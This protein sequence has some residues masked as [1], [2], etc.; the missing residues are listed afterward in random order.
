MSTYTAKQNDTFE[1][2][3]RRMYGTTTETGRLRSANPSL[4]DP[5]SAGDS[6]FVPAAKRIN[7]V[8]GSDD[9]VTLLINGVEYKYFTSIEF[10]QRFDSFDSILVTAPFEPENLS[11]R[12]SF[13]PFSYADI[14]VYIGQSLVFSGTQM[15]L[16]PQVTPESR[17]IIL[18][19]YSRCAVTNDS[20]LPV[21]SYPI[22]LR[23]MKLDRI[24]TE[25]CRP[26]PFSVSKDTDVGAVFDSASIGQPEKIYTFLTKLAKQRDLIITNDAQG[27]L[28]ITK[29]INSPS[30]AQ[31]S[32]G[33][34]PVVSVTPMHDNQNYFSDYTAIIPI[35]LDGLPVATY[36]AKN[37]RLQN[38][39][40][41]DNFE[42]N[43]S[44]NGEEKQVAESRRARGLA[45]SIAYNVE[46]ATVRDP[47][48]ALYRAGTFVNLQAIN[49]MIYRDTK[50][51]IRSVSMLLDGNRKTC[52][53]D[54]VLP[55]AYNGEDVEV[56]PWE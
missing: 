54:L 55:E 32:D 27:D 38:V 50:F 41:V 51:F 22:E 9:E 33:D 21:S 26:F 52:M 2:I 46:L 49:A 12:Q 20:S 56:F 18:E 11:F 37:K 48:G 45:N 1:K 17:T 35:M 7:R 16:T 6:V 36:T 31:L 13:T 53:L 8:T 23:G 43:D 40:R 28:L 42:A 47:N 15:G 39:L 3:S 10:Q 14:D 4:T 24:A 29:A 19:A 34:A 5:L 30:V 44:H 25:L